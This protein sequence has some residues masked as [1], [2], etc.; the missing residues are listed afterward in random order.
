MSNKYSAVI[1]DLDGTLIDSR[2]VIEQAWRYGASIVGQTIADEEMEK[3]VHGRSAEY[4]MSH[5]F[6]HL[7]AEVIADIKTEVNNFEEQAHSDL[8]AGSKEFLLKLKR[9]NIKV[10]LCTGS[11]RERVGFVFA[12]HNFAPLFDV[13]I[14]REDVEQGKPDPAGFLKCA[15]LLGVP[16][17]SCLLFEDSTSGIQAALSSGA[18]CIA[19][20]AQKEELSEKLLKEIPHFLQLDVVLNSN[21]IEVL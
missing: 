6:G 10:G 19:I 4:T 15:N 2:K 13:V 8:I 20:G 18:D 1:F 3:H 16:I 12:Q 9:A 11:W 7:K 5:F 17:E 21:E 14:T